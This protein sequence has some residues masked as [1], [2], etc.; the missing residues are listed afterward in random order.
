MFFIVIT[1]S[2]SSIILFDFSHKN[3]AY[4]IPPCRSSG[5]PLVLKYKVEGAA[6]KY[7]CYEGQYIIGVAIDTTNNGTITLEIPRKVL[8]PKHED[9]KRDIPLQAVI[10]GLYAQL[11]EKDLPTYRIISIP[12]T[13][14]TTHIEISDFDLFVP[15]YSHGI[16][17]DCPAAESEQLLPPLKQLAVGV[18]PKDIT[19]SQGLKLVFKSSNSS[20]V[21]LKPQTAQKLVERGWGLIKAQQSTE[22]VL[23][24]LNITNTNYSI[25]YHIVGGRLLHGIADAQSGSIVLSLNA[26]S[27]G[28]IT[29][30]FPRLKVDAS[31]TSNLELFVLEDRAEVHYEKMISPSERSLTFKFI[32]GT[33][34]IEIIG[35]AVCGGMP[36]GAGP[37]LK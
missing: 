8:N 22:K 11:D 21:C 31:C 4:A 18:L 5:H 6:V 16:K 20:P 26:T 10:N 30:I 24:S 37:F 9:C 19:C 7:I 35:Q 3:E 25:M 28:E 36:T 13:K 23:Q 12:F 33:K 14:G 29:A 1:I 17:M 32:N 15:E 2:S 27:D 34:E